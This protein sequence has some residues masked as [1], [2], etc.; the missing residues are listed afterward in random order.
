MKEYNEDA[1]LIFSAWNIKTHVTTEEALSI[2]TKGDT[3]G[4][5]KGQQG[6]VSINRMQPD[7]NEQDPKCLRQHKE[8]LELVRSWQF[9]GKGTKTEAT[10]KKLRSMMGLIMSTRTGTEYLHISFIPSTSDLQ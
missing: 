5:G 1:K 8:W 3:N 10:P 7:R 9:P 4:S 6:S 2:T